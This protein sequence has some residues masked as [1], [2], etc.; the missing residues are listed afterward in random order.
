MR[1]MQLLDRLGI[2]KASYDEKSNTCTQ[3]VKRYTN[4][5]L[6]IVQ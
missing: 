1:W 3:T 5:V 6:T 2:Q 4:K